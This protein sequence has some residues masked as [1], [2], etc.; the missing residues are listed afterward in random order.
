MTKMDRVDDNETIM[1]ETS[2]ENVKKKNIRLGDGKN[3]IMKQKNKCKTIVP[4]NTI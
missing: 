3:N 4:R 2:V 1:N